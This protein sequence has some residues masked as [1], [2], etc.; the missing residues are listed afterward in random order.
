MLKAES[1]RW[2]VPAAPGVFARD[3][4]ALLDLIELEVS[5]DLRKREINNAVCAAC[6]SALRNAGKLEE[7][8]LD[9]L[10]SETR[11]MEACKSLLCDKQYW[12][13]QEAAEAAGKAAKAH[14]AWRIE[15]TL[16][17][18]PKFAPVNLWFTYPIH[19]EDEAGALADIDPE[20]NAPIWKRGA[21]AR[22]KKSGETARL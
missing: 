1:G 9:D 22:K 20:G 15:G 4:D 8:S 16:R 18:F 3:P 19:R 12:A 2:T 21:E 5:E 6:S 14:T 11:S 17:E 7:V 10:C 13:L